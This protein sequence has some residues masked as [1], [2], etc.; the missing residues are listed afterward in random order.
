MLTSVRLAESQHRVERT[1]CDEEETHK[2]LD[3][4]SSLSL[5]SQY[6]GLE[7]RPPAMS[8]STTSTTDEESSR[9]LW[10][11]GDLSFQPTVSHPPGS[12]DTKGSQG[13]VSVDE[14]TE[15]QSANAFSDN[16]SE[17]GNSLADSLSSE[18]AL[19]YKKQYDATHNMK[20]YDFET[21]FQYTHNDA[22]TI[23]PPL[24]AEPKPLNS[25]ATEFSL[26][27]AHTSLFSSKQDS[28]KN[29]RETSRFLSDDRNLRDRYDGHSVQR[30]SSEKVTSIP[31]G[32]CNNNLSPDSYD[33]HQQ[34]SYNNMQHHLRNLCHSPQNN[35]STL[36][37]HVPSLVSDLPLG[38]SLG[39]T[40][41]LNQDITSRSPHLKAQYENIE[42]D[43][44]GFKSYQFSDST[45]DN[46]SFLQNGNMTSS[47]KSNA[48]TQQVSHDF[49]DYLAPQGPSF[50]HTMDVSQ[51]QRYQ[52]RN[53]DNLGGNPTTMSSLKQQLESSRIS[54][55]GSRFT[56]TAFPYSSQT[57]GDKTSR[58]MGNNHLVR[59]SSLTF[60]KTNFEE[61]AIFDEGMNY[62]HQ[63]YMQEQEIDSIKFQHESKMNFLSTRN[64]PA[65]EEAKEYSDLCTLTEQRYGVQSG[66]GTSENQVHSFVPSSKENSNQK[67]FS[68]TVVYVVKFKRSH[69]HFIT[70]QQ[71]S[72]D[73]KIG[74]YVKVEADRGEDLGIV[75]NHMSMSKYISSRSNLPCT[76][77]NASD[78]AFRPL[79]S[80][81]PYTVSPT[82]DLKKIVRLATNDE[83][84]LLAYKSE[85]ERELLKVCQEKVRQ[86]NLPMNVTDAEFQFD[87]NKLTFFFESEGRVDFRELVRDLFSIY[88][89]RIWMQQVDKN[90]QSTLGF[91]NQGAKLGF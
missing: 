48:D 67:P 29:N 58:F 3:G 53:N 77:E 56:Q 52:G 10:R 74:C 63:R 4:I 84:T 85:E 82:S 78:H 86:R 37:S 11:S 91:L 60:G 23:S 57:N 76:S 2:I 49:A 31:P 89:T 79:A 16:S 75:I 7:N 81:S 30:N 25:Y 43:Q 47:F 34:Q 44:Q 5:L 54:E 42:K 50:I 55:H 28:P 14:L 71:I 32:L 65:Y 38:S 64:P 46:M 72:R 18:N 1:L 73:L 33:Q 8:V 80:S 87:R 45:K 59:D 39:D 41:Y 17:N 27:K 70:G 51:Q 62:Q 83:V 9:S 40:S 6:S 22:I 35:L 69:R 24:N 36:R 19:S 13:F 12:P 90:S 88:K 26:S 68:P 15:K 66:H 61:K 20:T 21:P